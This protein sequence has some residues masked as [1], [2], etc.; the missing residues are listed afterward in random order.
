MTL[1]KSD[2]VNPTI[3]RR[4]Y[5]LSAN[6]RENGASGLS[7]NYLSNF[8]TSSSSNYQTYPGALRFLST[9]PTSMNLVIQPNEELVL[10]FYSRYY[11]RSF[12]TLKHN[13]SY[14]CTGSIGITCNYLLGRSD[15]RPLFMDKVVVR[16]NDTSYASQNFQILIPD[17]QIADYHSYHWYNLGIYN[18]IT[19]DYYFTYSARYHRNNAYWYNS[20]ST[21]TALSADIVG[22]AG[23][24][25]NSVAINVYSPSITTGADSYVFLCTQWSLF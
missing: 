3:Y 23:S 11:L 8:F 24:Y 18:K 12:P 5:S 9:N 13:D 15:S 21:Y 19:K 4:S 7:L 25:K 17:T 22:K 20:F 10:M 6:P 1:F 16:F 14:P 2:V